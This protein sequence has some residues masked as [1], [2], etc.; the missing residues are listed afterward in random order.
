MSIHGTSD[1]CNPYNGNACNIS[2]NALNDSLVD[3]HGAITPPA[4]QTTGNHTH[5][6]RSEGEDC[7][8]VEHIRVQNGDHAWPAFANQAIWDFVS[9]YDINDVIGCSGEPVPG[10]ISGDGIVDGADLGLML[11]YWSQCDNCPADLDGDGEVSGAD[12]GLLLVNWT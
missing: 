6:T 10:D 2:F 7:F 3:E 9:P 12:V 8:S 11:L 4:T 1:D 5:H